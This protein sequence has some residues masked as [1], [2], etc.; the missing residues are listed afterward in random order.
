VIAP[1]FWARKPY[2]IIA[3]AALLFTAPVSAQPRVSHVDFFGNR[4]VS[5]AAILRAA[6][7]ETG[8]LPADK[9]LI[10]AR[11][12]KLAGVAR[13][14]LEAYCC[15]DGKAILYIGVEERGAPHFEPLEE[16]S[17]DVST[18]SADQ[19]MGELPLE[20]KSID[21]IQLAA[22]DPDPILRKAATV[23]LVRLSRAAR[24]SNDPDLKLIIRPTWL[25]EM[26]NSLEWSDR[27]AAVNALLEL[28]E[29]DADPLPA[30][31]E[32]A[33]SSL[34][35]MAGW[36]HLPH[37]LPPYLLLCRVAGVT[38]EE[39]E[40]VWAGEQREQL[41]ARIVRPKKRPEAK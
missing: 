29:T 36:K 6:R 28:T 15:E 14:H 18:L 39:A 23:G 25:I 32:R 24:A 31:R 19:L 41:I 20:Q 40:K 35:Q 27:V 3:A 12:E 26:L 7:L 5:E 33:F 34:V 17:G 16:E 21:A 13:A 38:R 9:A 37:A 22:R 1:A 2:G 8:M 10:E 4:K 30:I 11:I